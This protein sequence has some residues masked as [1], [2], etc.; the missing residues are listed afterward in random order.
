MTAFKPLSVIRVWAA[1]VH[2][3]L[4]SEALQQNAWKRFLLQLL[5][6]VCMT[7]CW[8]PRGLL[9]GAKGFPRLG[10]CGLTVGGKGHQQGT[11]QLH[12]V[13]ANGSGVESS[14]ASGLCR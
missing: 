11:C 6:E 1:R 4:R 14:H 9:G 8:K 13:V 10:P 7:E 2:T 12:E 3:C 5:N